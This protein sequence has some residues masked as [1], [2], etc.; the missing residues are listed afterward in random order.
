[1]VICNFCNV[2]AGSK[3]LRHQKSA[4]CL[5]VQRAQG[6]NITDPS[7]EC[8][9][10]KK[11]F[12]RKDAYDT[13]TLTCKKA[14]VPADLVKA[15]AAVVNA[16]IT[17]VPQQAVELA[18]K[19]CEVGTLIETHV[20]K[21]SIILQDGYRGLGEYMGDPETKQLFCAL[22]GKDDFY[23]GSKG[24]ATFVY[25]NFLTGKNRPVYFCPSSDHT[26]FVHVDVDDNCQIITDPEC[27]DLDRMV[28]SIGLA[29][30]TSIFESEYKLAPPSVHP[31]LTRLHGEVTSGEMRK[32][33]LKRVL[34]ANLYPDIPSRVHGDEMN[35]PFLGSRK[36]RPDGFYVYSPWQTDFVAYPNCHYFPDIGWYNT[37]LGVSFDGLYINGVVD[38]AL[39]TSNPMLPVERYRRKNLTD[40]EIAKFHDLGYKI[41]WQSIPYLKDEDDILYLPYK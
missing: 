41:A 38:M 3:L 5:T 29:H 22:Y 11:R 34:G 7:H 9:S 2:D 4:E 37:V 13:H 6:I 31:Y 26:V 15:T 32:N 28:D 24:L 30:I 14:N 40:V 17:T 8:L 35:E 36:V 27:K 33:A 20:N 10:C 19:Q 25:E 21:Y 18:L 23:K 12:R 39:M 1:M 16:T